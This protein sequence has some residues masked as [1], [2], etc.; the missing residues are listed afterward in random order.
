MKVLSPLDY[1]FHFKEN[2]DAYDFRFLQD[3]AK[4]ANM[5][6]F[7]LIK[8]LDFCDI[9]GHRLAKHL[10]RKNSLRW[11][12][13]RQ[14][15]EEMVPNKSPLSLI[16]A[17]PSGNGKTEI[18]KILADL[19]NKPEDNAFHK[20]DCGKLSDSHEMFGMSGAFAPLC[21]LLLCF[22]E[23]TSK[24]IRESNVHFPKMIEKGT[25]Y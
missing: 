4:P 24:G 16:F 18:A 17:G 23:P 9:V 12:L 10:I 7:P 3:V 20:V 5:P 11:V 2:I 19:L 8:E 6:R 25:L 22:F 15:S 14:S 21:F 13:D 1:F